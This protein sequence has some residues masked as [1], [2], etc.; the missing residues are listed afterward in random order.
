MVFRAD[1]LRPLG[2]FDSRPNRADGISMAGPPR[3][4][5]VGTV[6]ATGRPR[7]QRQPATSNQHSSS[8]KQWFGG[9]L[10]WWSGGLVVW[11]S[12]GLVVWST[13]PPVDQTDQLSR[14]PNV[15]SE[16]LFNSCPDSSP[17]NFFW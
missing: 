1:T 7:A 16:I 14:L 8:V 13:R 9:L 5:L 2:Y 15:H 12:G 3:P 10:V 6:I 17:K 4:Q 11:W